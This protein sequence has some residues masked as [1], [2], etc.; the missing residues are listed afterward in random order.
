MTRDGKAAG[1]QASLRVL[2]CACANLRRASRAAN[3]LYGEQLRE[4]GLT[5]P[6]F[7]LLQVLSRAGELTQAGLAQILVLDSTTLT[8][9]LRP[10]ERRGWIRRRPGRD[11]RER[12]IVL[13][14]SGRAAFRRALPAWE[15]AQDIYR[16]KVGPRR[17]RLLMVEL[18]RLAAT[19]PDR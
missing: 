14:A 10:L 16:A 17:W 5:M 13:T 1:R 11:R 3:R 15:R 7:T 8:R 6:Q 2:P 19:A 12:R 18:S 9:N 4:A